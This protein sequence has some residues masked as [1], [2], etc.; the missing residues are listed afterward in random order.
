M[1]APCSSS[2]SRA[3]CL[4][5]ASVRCRSSMVPSVFMSP[6]TTGSGVPN[7]S[8]SASSEYTRASVM[9]SSGR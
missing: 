6:S 1:F 5:L 2:A 3:F 9:R 8:I 4:R 7:A